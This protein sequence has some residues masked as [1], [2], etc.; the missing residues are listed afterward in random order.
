MEKYLLIHGEENHW[1][2]ILLRLHWRQERNTTYK[3]NILITANLLLPNFS[4][5]RPTKKKIIQT[6][7][8]NLLHA[9]KNQI[10][11][12]LLLALINSLHV[13]VR[14][15]RVLNYLKTKKYLFNRF[16]QPILKPWW[17]W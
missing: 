8:Q 14:M 13:K 17:Y 15:G 4:G 16:T 11:P 2:Q 3:P 12:L 6:S 7:L 9:Q 10:S 5:K 1:F